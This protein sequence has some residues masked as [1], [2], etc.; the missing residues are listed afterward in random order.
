MK[1]PVKVTLNLVEAHGLTNEEYEKIRK[2]L[3]REPNFT[4]L[5]IFS[6]MWSEHCSYKSSKP[7]LKLFPTQNKYILVKTG[8]EN[9]GVVDIG[10]GLAVVFKIESH[11]HPSAVEP[12][13]GA[14]TGAGGV[15]RDIFT[16]GARPIALMDSL[17]FG[18]LE[19]PRSQYLLKRV[20]EG[21]AGYGDIM[22]IPSVGGELF[23]DSTYE[24]NPLVNAMCL[25]V[26]QKDKIIKAKATGTG[27]SVFYVGASTGRDGLGGASFA[28]QEISEE[29]Y[30][31]KP[32]VPK[33]NPSMEKILL[34][35][36]LE[37][38]DSGIV[39]GMQDMGAAGLTSS[40]A[41]TASKGDSGVEINISLVPRR[42]EGMI[43][44]EIM[45]SESQERML[46]IVKKE[47][48]R[49]AKKIFEK[50]DLP[51]VKIGK[52]TSDGMFRVLDKGRVVAEIPARS[53]AQDAP[54]YIRKTKKPDYLKKV[55]SLDI[56]H[57]PQL[58]DYNRVLKEL[59]DSPNVASKSWVYEQ[60]NYTVGD[61]TV[62]SPGSD[63]AVLRIKTTKKALA[64]SC[65][66]NGH[67][68]YLDP[69]EGGK[70]AVAEAARNLICSGAKPLAITNCLNFGTPTDPE[71]F[72]QFTRCVEGMAEACQVLNTPVSGGNVSFYNENPKGSI[73]PTPVV[74]MVGLIDDINFVS[75]PWFKKEGDLILLLGKSREELGGS[76]YLY[77]IHSLKRGVP[78]SVDLNKEK[79]IQQTCLEVIKKGLVNSAHDCS[80]GGLTIALTECCICNIEKRWGAVVEFFSFCYQG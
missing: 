76:E 31:V 29:S 54:V 27:N 34:E 46:I 2:I 61:S 15:I 73:D 22:E 62:V 40:T 20:V 53:L 44:Y 79:A 4:E 5:G 18:K 52:V 10:D 68:C 1:E 47:K 11:N 56:S 3:G 58:Q 32:A 45:L 39:V 65:D 74:G 43:P 42:E 67:Y 69:Y 17:R 30:K 60:Y 14:A 26:V 12:Y 80:E 9:A 37:L 71:V 21:I 59:L 41:E 49:E 7:V 23:F 25:G 63:S 16:M 33:G 48:E 75:T 19:N 51:A 35:A 36:S 50:W 64:M 55:Q 38:I 70:I 24:G 57:I 28:S 6:V 72:W 13:E 66:G 8:E 78:P 77:F